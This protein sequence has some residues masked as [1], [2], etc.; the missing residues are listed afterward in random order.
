MYKKKCLDMFFMKTVK[1]KE[2]I[3]I[4]KGMLTGL[5]QLATWAGVPT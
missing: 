5:G 3:G 4:I 2:K 1:I